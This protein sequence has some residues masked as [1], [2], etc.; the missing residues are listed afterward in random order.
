M[1]KFNKILSGCRSLTTEAQIVSET[2]AHSPFHRLARLLARE[3]LL[4]REKK[5]VLG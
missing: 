3:P 2:L 4:A 1:T 5:E